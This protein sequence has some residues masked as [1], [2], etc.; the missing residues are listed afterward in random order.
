MKVLFTKMASNRALLRKIIGVVVCLAVMVIGVFT[1][2]HLTGRSRTAALSTPDRGYS[3]SLGE[4]CESKTSD[5]TIVFNHAYLTREIAG[6]RKDSGGYLVVAGVID[7]QNVSFVTED[8]FLTLRL[9][10][11]MGM[12]MLTPEDRLDKELSQALSKMELFFFDKQHCDGT[13]TGEFCFVFSINEDAYSIIAEGASKCS[14]ELEIG[15][16]PGIGWCGGWSVWY[17]TAR[18]VEDIEKTN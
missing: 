5:N 4:I 6:E 14:D 12:D 17:F 18:D 8:I 15:L 16:D 13:M 9:R 3:F 10:K 11:G 2:H 1:V 7:A